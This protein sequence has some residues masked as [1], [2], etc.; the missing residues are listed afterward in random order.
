M[1]STRCLDKAYHLGA[2][3]SGDCSRVHA[4][5]GAGTFYWRPVSRKDIGL[6]TVG[7]HGLDVPRARGLP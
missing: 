1:R 5:H 3:S 4:T 7:H 6:K 2:S